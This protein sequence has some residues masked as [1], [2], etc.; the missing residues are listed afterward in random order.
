MQIRAK[1]L[2]AEDFAKY[3]EVIDLSPSVEPTVSA[4]VLDYWKQ[5]AVF[6]IDGPAE[7]GVLKVKKHEMVF[8]KMEQHTETPEI[9]IGQGGG[10]VVPVAPPSDDVPSPDKIEAFEVGPRQAI[11]LK[12]S[13]WHWVPNPA[14]KDELT[15]LVLFKDNTSA[16]DLVVKDIAEQCKVVA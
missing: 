5:Q 9:L 14:D 13:C 4:E 11:M 12:R 2:T 8:E 7:I 3:G 10:F 1:K 15:I 6:S 16:D